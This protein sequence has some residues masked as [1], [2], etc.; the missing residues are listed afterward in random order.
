[1]GA[2]VLTKRPLG[3]NVPYPQDKQ[4]RF[5][6]TDPVGGVRGLIYSDKAGT[7]VLEESD[8][9]GATWSTSA[10]VSVSVAT[11]AKL[12]WIS[13][14]KRWYRFKYTNGAAAQTI[15]VLIQQTRGM[16]LGD[17]QLTGTRSA[18]ITHR[19]AV[20][21]D[22]KLLDF[23][24][25]DV[26]IVD[27]GVGTG[28]LAA[29]TAHF[30]TAAPGNSYGNTKVSAA[31]DTLTTAAYGAATG[32]I[33]AT[34]AQRVGA[35]YYD[36]FCSTDAAPKWVAR[37]TEAQRAA[38]G[39][40]VSAYGVVEASAGVPAGAVD[41]CVVGT[42]VAT[43]AAPFTVN[44]AFVFPAPNAVI[45]MLGKQ[46]LYLNVDVNVTDLRIAPTATMVLFVKNPSNG[47]WYQQSPVI[48]TVLNASS[49]LRKSYS[50]V[51]PIASYSIAGANEVMVLLDVMVGQ[52]ISVDIY[53][54]TY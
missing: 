45:S 2:I 50:I 39:F 42:G 23:T 11:T 54:E 52:G 34:I 19:L 53:A 6:D 24:A 51:N 22:D 13:L 7:L 9:D 21:A 1:M 32:S 38:G 18:M 35:D 28:S 14:S 47:L 5:H 41:I 20:T 40:K 37:I 12:D 8:D 15:F 17:V 25:G 4:D 31:I 26:T 29:S 36:L 46:S 33:R 44:T 16:E 43:S 30:V 48:I 10:T 3:I 49:P 27:G